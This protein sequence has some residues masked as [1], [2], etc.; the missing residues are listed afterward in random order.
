VELNDQHLCPACLETGRKKGKLAQLENKRT[1]YDSSAL[2]LS[3]LPVLCAW[4]VSIVTAP[5][6]IGLAI[7]SWSKPTSL[8]PRS[9]IRSYLAI[10]F[11]VLELAVWTLALTG[12]WKFGKFR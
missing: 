2:M 7:Y 3:V 10:L 6:A 12:V 5:A 1:L 11:G 8:L 9:R 4:P